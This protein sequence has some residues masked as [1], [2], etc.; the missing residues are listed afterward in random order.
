MEDERVETRV[1]LRRW[2]NGD[3]IAIIWDVPHSYGSVMMYEH[4][5][6]HGEGSYQGVV[7]QTTLVRVFDDGAKELMDE[8]KTIGYDIRVV[9]RRPKGA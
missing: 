8:L 3:V 6:Q 1:T 5:G 7:T 9:Y 4:V 2:P